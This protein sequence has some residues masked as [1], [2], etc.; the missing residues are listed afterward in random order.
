[1]SIDKRCGISPAAKTNRGLAGKSRKSSFRAQMNMI[2]CKRENRPD[3]F[4]GPGGSFLLRPSSF[5][6]AN[7]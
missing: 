7:I 1:M 4:T 5:I 3:L 6:S 2:Q